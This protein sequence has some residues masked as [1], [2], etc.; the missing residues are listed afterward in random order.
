MINFLFNYH[1]TP[2]YVWLNAI[3]IYCL[4][5]LYAMH[6]LIITFVTYIFIITSLTFLFSGQNS[7]QLSEPSIE[8]IKS[9]IEV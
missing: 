2:Y 1:S 3:Y 8:V 6:Q 7:D 5:A 9:P 4:E